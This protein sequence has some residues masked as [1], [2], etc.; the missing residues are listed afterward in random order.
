MGLLL[1]VSCDSRNE[2][3]TPQR[4]HDATPRPDVASDVFRELRQRPLRVPKIPPSEPCY[5][6]RWAIHLAGVPNEAVLGK[7]PVHLAFSAIPRN[8]DLFPTRYGAAFYGSRWRGGEALLV[9][10][11]NYDG[12]I[13]LRGGQMDGP[14]RLGFGIRADP[15]WELFLPEGSWDV[16][17]ELSVWGG[18]RL[19]LPVDWR[20]QR[21]TFRIEAD[22]C[23]AVQLDGKGFSQIIEFSA[24]LQ[25]GPSQP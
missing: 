6:E 5:L 10:E 18:E 23:Y 11:P 8:L 19:S 4:N 15:E 22:G 20:A 12:P 9:S 7:G 17:D 14:H 3:G 2:D 16:V 13:L 24:I 1:L 25:P 21:A